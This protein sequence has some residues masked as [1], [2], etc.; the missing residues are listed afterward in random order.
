MKYTITYTEQVTYTAT[1]E[2]TSKEE[3][4]DQF[5]TECIIEDNVIDSEAVHTS[6][7]EVSEVQ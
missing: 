1:V 3:A 6:I 2:A 7:E 5:N 4:L